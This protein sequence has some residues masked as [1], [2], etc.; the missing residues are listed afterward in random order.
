[1]S[2]RLLPALAILGSLLLAGCFP[3]STNP[4]STPATSTVDPRLEGVYVAHRD[5]TDD[6]LYIYHLHYRGERG[7]VGGPPLVTPWLEILNI[8]HSKGKPLEGI[9]YRALTTH[10]GGHDYMSVLELGSVTSSES[11]LAKP[12]QAE[13]ARLY[14]I[15]RYEIDGAGMLRVWMM[16]IKAWEDAI[17][18]GKIHGQIKPHKE[19][20]DVLV[21]DSTENLAK[22]V[23]KGDPAVLFGGKP[24][25][26]YRLAR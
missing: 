17:K 6:G 22:L 24:L 2:P 8:N 14:W 11:G 25:V 7:S 3:E 10:L 23:T 1:M 19:G 16:N 15:A 21:A 12:A 18:T 5:K 4:L 26:L 9:A 20:D 13:N